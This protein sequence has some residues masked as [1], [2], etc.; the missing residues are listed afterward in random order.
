MSKT[1]EYALKGFLVGGVL[2]LILRAIF[3]FFIRHWKGV[4]ISL[5]FVW[6][7]YQISYERQ[8]NIIREE[9]A[10]DVSLVTFQAGSIRKSNEWGGKL[11]TVAFTIT[12]GSKFALRDIGVL[13]YFL[14]TVD[15]RDYM[16]LDN[17]APEM[18]WVRGL[19][20]VNIMVQPGET[21]Q[22][23]VMFNYQVIEGM[24]GS[25]Q[26]CKPDFQWDE[27]SLMKDH[28][29]LDFRTQATITSLIASHRR[30][31][32]CLSC[33][34]FYDILVLGTLVN[35]SKGYYAKGGRISCQVILDTGD[36][37]RYSDSFSALVAPG[38]SAPFEVKFK[39]IDRFGGLKIQ[40]I[41]CLP[42]AVYQGEEALPN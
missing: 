30:Q 29:E 21:R 2:A 35:N 41:S 5:F 37:Y 42:D 27:A 17:P 8:R 31:H 39:K 33:P 3:R 10:K 4:L 25:F 34:I 38:Q 40:N 24:K 18:E 1:R 26:N 6:G 14:P 32:V 22:F 20:R 15:G 28:P 11:D 7:W 23:E 19:H 9:A 36:S 13:C 12:N 16:D